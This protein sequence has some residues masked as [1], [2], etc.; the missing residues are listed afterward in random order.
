M[1]SLVLAAW[2]MAV[3]PA[4]ANPPIPGVG[5]SVVMGDIRVTLLAATRLYADECRD[6]VGSD[7]LL[8]AGG[9][10]RLTFLVEN[11]PG[12]PAPP[13]LG[14]LRVLVGSQPYNEVTNAISGKPFAPFAHVRSVE[15]FL[16]TGYG[17]RVKDRVPKPRPDAA[18]A[19]LELLVRG[20]PIPSAADAIIEL[21]QG[22]TSRAAWQL[23]RFRVPSIE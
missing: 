17:R 18:A 19:V 16:A 10:V 7:L 2:A 9:G 12:A 20:G 14:E 13:A 5:E 11:R 1:L 22:E 6:A 21:E 4:A 23:F 3:A 8:W 15:A